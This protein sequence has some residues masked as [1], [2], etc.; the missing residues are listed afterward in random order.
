[1][2]DDQK[3]KEEHVHPMRKLYAD[4]AGKTTEREINE[5]NALAAGIGFSSDKIIALYL[6]AG[7]STIWKW[8]KDG[9]L[10][11]PV[12]ITKSHSRWSNPEILPIL[13]ELGKGVA[14][15]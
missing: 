4:G 6:G 11:P 12:K 10:P 1:M 13:I 7:R 9:L 5:L 15:E 3:Q 2:N 14:D 8:V